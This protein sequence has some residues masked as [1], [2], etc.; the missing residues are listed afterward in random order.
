[1]LPV[2]LIQEIIRQ[3][4]CLIVLLITRALVNIIMFYMC[5]AGGLVILSALTGS[6]VIE[7]LVADTLVKPYVALSIAG[8]LC[9]ISSIRGYYK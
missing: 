3:V 4:L 8:V 5:I 7:I 6:R 9:L 2:K 1:M